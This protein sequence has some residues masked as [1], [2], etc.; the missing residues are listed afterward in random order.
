MSIKIRSAKESDAPFLAKMIL[1]SSRAGKKAGMF[2]IAF[3][4]KDDKKTIKKLEQLTKTE[5]K[6]YCH[7]KNFLVAEMDGKTVGTLCNYEPRIATK[8]QFL[9][10]LEEVGCTDK[11]AE[12][13]EVFYSC[14]FDI[15]N[16][17]LMFDF[18]EEAEGFI[19]VGIL[20]ALMQKSLLTA[21]LKGYRIAQTVIEIGSLE[22]ELFYKKLNF[23]VVEQKECELYQEAFGR[24]GLML[25]AT[26]F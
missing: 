25:L 21:R 3:D 2:D 6:N 22:S 20:K 13:L 14:Q 9:L 12:R 10:A 23:H 5:A 4:M 18:M 16:R 7:Y 1:Q 15:N 26:E 11:A 8:E 19:D 24:L 17:T